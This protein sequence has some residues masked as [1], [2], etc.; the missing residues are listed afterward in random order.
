MLKYL[1]NVFDLVKFVFQLEWQKIE[2]PA[3][4]YSLSN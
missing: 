4:S 2:V 3:S 1:L